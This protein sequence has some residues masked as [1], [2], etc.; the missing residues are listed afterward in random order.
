MHYTKRK[1]D[2]FKRLHTVLFYLHGSQEEVIKMPSD[3]HLAEKIKES[4]ELI[5]VL[6]FKSTF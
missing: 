4:E 5:S 2:R 3:N 1:K 6:Q